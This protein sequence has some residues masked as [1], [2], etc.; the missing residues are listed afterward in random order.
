MLM[1][2][3]TRNRRQ[4]ADEL[5]IFNNAIRKLQFYRDMIERPLYGTYFDSKFRRFNPGKYKEIT[6]E[7]V[8]R[9]F[10]CRFQPKSLLPFL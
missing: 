9:S 2:P 5:E 4:L 3:L 6:E 8:T 10:F 7:L 1:V